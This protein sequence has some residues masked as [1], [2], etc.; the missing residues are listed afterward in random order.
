MTESN[1]N[2][3][4]HHLKNIVKTD[5]GYE[6]QAPY[7]ENEENDDVKISQAVKSTYNDKKCCDI[8]IY[9]ITGRFS[10]SC[11]IREKLDSNLSYAHWNNLCDA[12][13]PVHPL[14][15]IKSEKDMIQFIEKTECFFGCAEEYEAYYGFE[16][17]WDE[18]TGEVLETVREYYNRGGKFENIPDKYP[19]VIYFS[20]TDLDNESYEKDNLKWIYV[21]E[22]KEK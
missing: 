21:G 18:E 2:F 4:L 11:I 19:C 5:T 12:Y 14:T 15:V 3:F 8:C 1:K 9:H 6:L 20:Y 13:T 7:D 17:K 22:E 16:R 10:G